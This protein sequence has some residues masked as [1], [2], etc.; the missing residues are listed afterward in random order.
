MV[1][2]PPVKALPVMLGEFIP[3]AMPPK[4]VAAASP[5][6]LL[7]DAA[8]SSTDGPKHAVRVQVSTDPKHTQRVAVKGKIRHPHK[9][10]IGPYV[11]PYIG[12]YGPYR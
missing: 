7:R 11:G 12:P 2:P 3:A 8:S 9:G 6:K 4:A 1:M 5:P 10:K